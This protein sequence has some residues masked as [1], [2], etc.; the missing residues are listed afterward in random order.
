MLLQDDA[1]LATAL[2]VPAGEELGPRVA[3]ELVMPD[4]EV[5]EGAEI[6]RKRGQ[7]TP[8]R[9]RTSLQLRSRRRF[10]WAFA[11]S[12]SEENTMD[13][14]SAPHLNALAQAI[15]SGLSPDPASWS[16]P[17]AMCAPP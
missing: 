10:S 2:I 11:R 6:P 8:A 7:K 4:V 5:D 17:S 1:G 12:D 9:V 16:R 15:V 13:L 14:S 3:V